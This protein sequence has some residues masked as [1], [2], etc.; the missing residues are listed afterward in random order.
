MTFQ[1][2]SFVA[3]VAA[4]VAVFAVP[5]NAQAQDTQQQQQ[6]QAAQTAPVP[7]SALISA[8]NNTSD[9]IDA[10]NALTDLTASDVQVA[11]ASSVLQGEQTD[12]FDQALQNADTGAVQEFL[13]S[14]EVT[15]EVLSEEQIANAI[16]VH[17]PSEG[18]VVVFTQQQ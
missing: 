3:L 17:A 12:A 8:L 16:A 1:K 6:Q 7:P 9:Q 10:V 15:S 4:L 2:A 13:S 11:T 5:N 18:G 14:N